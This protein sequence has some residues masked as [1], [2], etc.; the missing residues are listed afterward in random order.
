MNTTI[1]IGG[2]Q[3]RKYGLNIY[4]Y[5]LIH[6][7]LKSILFSEI[8]EPFDYE[9][10]K[11]KFKYFGKRKFEKVHPQTK[12]VILTFADEP[13]VERKAFIKNKMKNLD[14]VPFK[15]SQGVEYTYDKHFDVYHSNYRL[16]STRAYQWTFRWLNGT[17]TRLETLNICRDEV[18]PFHPPH[19]NPP[20]EP[21][22]A[23]E[24]P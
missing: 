17:R 11:E 2:I 14:L 19:K 13:S 1:G 3:R 15:A 16:S 21:Y 6:G 18:S 12:G 4:D 9:L 20:C 8:R 5:P 24:S 22:Y 23:F 10:Q 7:Y